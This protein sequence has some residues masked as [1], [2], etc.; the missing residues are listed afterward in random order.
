MI[1]QLHKNALRFQYLEIKRIFWL[2]RQPRRMQRI[3]F[4][5]VQRN[6][7]SK[8]YPDNPHLLI[9]MKL[10]CKFQLLNDMRS[11]AYVASITVNDGNSAQLHIVHTQR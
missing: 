8:E 3:D 6:G 11:I 5:Q 9:K 2:L 7:D 1:S 4:C 10:R